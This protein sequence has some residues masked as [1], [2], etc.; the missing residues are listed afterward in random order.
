MREQESNQYLML[1]TN[2]ARLGVHLVWENEDVSFAIRRWDPDWEVNGLCW[3]E[4]AGRSLNVNH[5]IRTKLCGHNL[6]IVP[7]GV[8]TESFLSYQYLLDQ[9]S[10]RS[11]RVNSTKKGRNQGLHR[12]YINWC[13]LFRAPRSN[14]ALHHDVEPSV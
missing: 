9:S 3:Y 5:Q 12:A 13:S 1:A 2:T 7:D 14:C 4:G 10:T 6:H 8:K 11:D